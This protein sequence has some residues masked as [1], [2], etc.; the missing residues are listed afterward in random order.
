M[1]H[2][3]ES[4][5]CHP[6]NQGVYPSKV[7]YGFKNDRII[8]NIDTHK[9]SF[10]RFSQRFFRPKVRYIRV[11]VIDHKKINYVHIQ[12]TR[13][14]HYYRYII[15]HKAIERKAREARGL[16]ISYTVSNRYVVAQKYRDKWK[17]DL[18]RVRRYLDEQEF[19]QSK[20]KMNNNSNNRRRR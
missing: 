16:P 1:E 3:H 17:M 14:R 10:W 7:R 18:Q 6:T 8:E 13:I 4:S 15:K 5:Y 9:S 20:K 11:G 2:T 12:L 19:Q